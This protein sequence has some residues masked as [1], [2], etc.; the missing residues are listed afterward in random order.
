[1]FAVDTNVLLYASDVSFVVEHAR[2]RQLLDGW[3]RRSLP[4]YLTW[5]IV[6]EYIRVVTHPRV[7][8]RPWSAAEAWSFI[9]A[10]LA[11][12]SLT[13]LVHTSRHPPIARRTLGELPSLRGN[14][15][16]DTHTAILLREHGVASI[17]TRD[18]DFHRFPFL[19]VIDPLAP[20]SSSG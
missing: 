9:E 5:G 19:T 15:V 3:R 1:M 12:P 16:H 14:I 6:Y 11:A 2:C 13:V 20:D 7:L 17:Y 4:W 8:A 18:T 10:L